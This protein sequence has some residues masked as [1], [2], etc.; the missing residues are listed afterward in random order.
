MNKVALITGASAGIGL[1]IAHKLAK[2]NCDLI[3]LSRSIDKLRKAQKDIEEKYQVKSTVHSCDVSNPKEVEK[4][5]Q[6][7]Q[8]TSININFLVNN[9]GISS[10]ASIDALTH[11]QFQEELLTNIGGTHYISK[12][13]YPLMKR[14]GAIVNLSSIRGRMGSPH[15]SPGYSAAKAGIIALTKTYALQLARHG[16]RVNA[17][18]PGAIYPTEMTARWNEE[19]QQKIIEE[20]IIKR[21]G[22]PQEVADAV[23]FLLSE[24]AAF[25]TGHTLD[26]NGGNY[27]N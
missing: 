10:S 15:S 9:A 26:V 13:F 21:L 14:G 22:S 4:V 17:V 3:L 25:I 12:A 20:S 2:E 11:E 8:K 24:K 19:K 1:A 16:I 5:A 7:V 18:A 6:F 27:M 23:Y